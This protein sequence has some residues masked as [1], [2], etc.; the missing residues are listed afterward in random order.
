MKY[1]PVVLATLAA[2]SALA[3]PCAHAQYK[4]V[5][6]DGRVSYTDRPPVDG[7]RVTQ[8]TTQSGGG[9]DETALPYELRMAIQRNPVILYTADNCDPCR[10]GKDL[11]SKRGVPF[12]E[13]TLSSEE[14]KE[15][16]KTAM[17]SAGLPALKVG[18]QKLTG[19]EAGAWN[20]ALDGAGYPSVAKL[21]STFK[22]AQATTA[23]P[24]AAPKPAPSKAPAPRETVAAPPAAGGIRF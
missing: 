19:Y 4:V 3:A 7:S 13:K 1:A 20:G 5:G 2:V 11:L 6:A 21:P 10:A 22:Q 16:V 18:S 17:G 15:A 9:V 14:D 8:V 23:A 12:Q 24:R